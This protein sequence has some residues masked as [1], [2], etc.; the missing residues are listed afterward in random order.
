MNGIEHMMLKH[1]N[2]RTYVAPVYLNIRDHWMVASLCKPQSED[3]ASCS[4]VEW[5]SNRVIQCSWDAIFGETGARQIGF[6]HELKVNSLEW[7]GIK[8]HPSE[9][10][11]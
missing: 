6:G 2:T 4:I 5:K 7:A 8:R 3:L 9:V 11:A 10:N 1:S